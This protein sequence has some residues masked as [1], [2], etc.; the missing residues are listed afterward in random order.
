MIQELRPVSTSKQD[1][2]SIQLYPSGDEDEAHG[3]ESAPTSPNGSEGPPPLPPRPTNGESSIQRQEETSSIQ[4]SLC[5]QVGPTI[6]HRDDLI[7]RL[8]DIICGQPESGAHRFRIMTIQV[9]TELLLELVLTKASPGTSVKESS[10]GNSAMQQAAEVQL[11]EVRL[12]RLA[13]AE[14]QFRERVQ[15][16][17]REL[18]SQK[19]SVPGQSDMVRQPLVM[20]T[21]RV[22]RALTE[23][24]RKFC[25]YNYAALWFLDE[26]PHF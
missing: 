3:N 24:K 20:M 4:E 18:E 22:E 19:K 10:Q 17:I 23:S 16:G 2:D 9:A 11:G 7:D 8:V 6:Q 26:N 13:L 21:G 12:H 14:A 25:W 1:R 15:K 5:T